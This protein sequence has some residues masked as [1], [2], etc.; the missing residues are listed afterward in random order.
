[1]SNLALPLPVVN[2]LVSVSVRA[3]LSGEANTNRDNKEVLALHL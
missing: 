3:S 1:M 2:M